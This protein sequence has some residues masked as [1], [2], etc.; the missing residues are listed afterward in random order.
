MNEKGQHFMR[1]Q[2]KT[3]QSMAC[4]ACIAAGLLLLGCSRSGPAGPQG[5]SAPEVSVMTVKTERLVLTTELPGRTAAFRVAEIR[6]QVNGLVQKRLFEEGS[7][8]K[9]GQV[10]YRIDPAPFQAALDSAKASSARAEAALGS[11]RLRSERYGDLLTDKA[12]SRQDYDDTVAAMK[13]AE[14]QVLVSKAA[15]ETASINLGY[16]KIKAPIP[17]RIGKSSVTEGA[18]VAAYQPLALATIQQL[19]PIYVD[20][21]QSTAELLQLKQRLAD[22]RLSHDGED[23]NKVTIIQEDGTPY[24]LEGT[25]EFRDVTVDPSTGSV[26]LRIVVPN[27]EGMLLPGMF[28]RAV[29]REGANEKAVLVPQQTVRRT[30]KGAPFV[31]VAD[32][33]DTAVMRMLTLDRAI[34]DKWLVSSGLTAGDRIIVEGIQKVRPDMPVKVV[35]PTLTD[36]SNSTSEAT[37]PAATAN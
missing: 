37:A 10:L 15:V 30:H 23:Q 26:I 16:T 17:G 24:P 12:V 27:P 19:D 33:N 6:P 3:K 35:D 31:L 25:L 18:L 8:V 32:E 36:E 22:G 5:M 1:N 29:L 21:P 14:A 13:Q 11:I 20:V 34:G 2:K 9:E 4:L 7:D 28:V